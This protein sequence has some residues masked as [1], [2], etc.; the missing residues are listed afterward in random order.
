[1][2]TSIDSGATHNAVASEPE[3][4]KD[5]QAPFPFG[6][7]DLAATRPAGSED[8]DRRLSARSDSREMEG[9]WERVNGAAGPRESILYATAP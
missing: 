2:V 9:R 7:S 4:A 5:A 8:V 6:L 3:I 1:M